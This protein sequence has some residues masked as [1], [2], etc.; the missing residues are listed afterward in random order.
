MTRSPPAPADDA[1][2]FYSK[3]VAYYALSNFSP[4]G[5]EQDGACDDAIASHCKWALHV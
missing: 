2:R 5:F 4:H 1:I 3:S